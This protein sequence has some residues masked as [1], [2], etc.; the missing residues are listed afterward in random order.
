MLK[1][2]LKKLF[3]RDLKQL[4]IEINLYESEDHLWLARAETKNSAG[5]LCLHLIGN[6][7]HFL[8]AILNKNGYVRDRP[9]EFSSRTSKADLSQ[10]I[11]ETLAVVLKTL[12]ELP[13]EKWQ[14]IY[15][16]NV[17]GEEMTTEYFL[18]HLAT[19]LSYHLGQINYHRRINL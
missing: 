4:Q 14:E 15:P 18:V 5:N 9:L 11:D 13:E 10:K 2:T 6:L 12:D 3:E 16:I 17:F 1:E 19:H 7:K 8:G